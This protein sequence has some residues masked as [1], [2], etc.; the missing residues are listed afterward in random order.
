[1]ISSTV[2]P[3]HNSLS[4]LPSTFSTPSPSF[5]PTP[6][7]RLDPNQEP[8]I[9]GY[10]SIMLGG[11]VHCPHQHKEKRRTGTLNRY[12]PPGSPSPS[13]FDSSESSSSS[14]EWSRGDSGLC[15]HCDSIAKSE[16]E[17]FFST[18]AAL[19]SQES[20]ATTKRPVQKIDPMLRMSQQDPPPCNTFYLRGKCATGSRCRY[21]HDY[22]LNVAQL[23]EIRRGAK[24][25]P[26]S[27]VQHGL[28]CPDGESCIYG[29]SCPKGLN[30]RKADCAFGADINAEIID[31]HGFSPAVPLRELVYPVST[32]PIEYYPV[33]LTAPPPAM[34]TM[35]IPVLP[36]YEIF[37]PN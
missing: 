33:Y 10:G 25:H 15:D 26:C 31:L 27:A 16:L 36:T 4:S 34:T 7:S 6:L 37:W 2:T 19:N 30:C 22:E 13:S 11:E 1:M 29:H 21:G 5:T 9:P 35:R 20:T 32:P 12:E 17:R 24:W 23:E 14:V 28:E 3:D 18:L 8:F